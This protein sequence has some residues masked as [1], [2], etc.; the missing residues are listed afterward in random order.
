MLGLGYVEST[1][2]M[3]ALGKARKG[4]EKGEIFEGS[5]ER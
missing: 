1:A 4:F 5:W 2:G 3:S